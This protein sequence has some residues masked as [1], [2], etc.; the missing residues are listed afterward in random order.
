[1]RRTRQSTALFALDSA[2]RAAAAAA[3]AALDLDSAAAASALGGPLFLF[4]VAD[5]SL[6][7]NRGGAWLLDVEETEEEE[8]AATAAAKAVVE[9]AGSALLCEAACVAPAAAAAAAEGG[10]VGREAA[11]AATAAAGLWR[12]VG[13]TKLRSSS[14]TLRKP[15]LGVLVVRSSFFPLPCFLTGQES[16]QE[17]AA[18]KNLSQARFLTGTIPRNL[19]ARSTQ[20]KFACAC[21]KQLAASLFVA[22]APTQ[23][24]LLVKVAHKPQ[25]AN[26]N[27]HDKVRTE[28]LGPCQGTHNA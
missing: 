28:P 2:P 9:A 15:S 25:A 22:G 24:Q 20:S 7:P 5:A 17:G 13:M 10:C 27:G 19:S 3:A 4:F 21:S 14:T 26:Q 18:L 12:M 23:S 1:M 16:S 6:P 11:A 8:E